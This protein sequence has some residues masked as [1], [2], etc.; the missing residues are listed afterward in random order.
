MISTHAA[1]EHEGGI[2]RPQNVIHKT[3]HLID[4]LLL[5]A[6]QDA[7]ADKEESPAE[8]EPASALLGGDETVDLPP[9]R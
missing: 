7:P 9:E 6:G 2:S 8:L 4:T 1:T 5:F 3:S